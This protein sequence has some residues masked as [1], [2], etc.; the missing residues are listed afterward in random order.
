MHVVRR[1]RD[2]QSRTIEQSPLGQYAI[3][4][5]V[6]KQG[7]V[8]VEQ[9]AAVAIDTA[10]CRSSDNDCRQIRSE[11]AACERTVS[12]AG[13]PQVDGDAQTQVHERLR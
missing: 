3:E 1:E 10:F 9:L 7:S 11:G 5:Q 12:S 8:R 4:Q 13:N 2:S 6:S